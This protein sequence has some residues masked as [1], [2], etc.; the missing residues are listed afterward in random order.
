[1]LIRSLFTTTPLSRFLVHELRRLP[2]MPF[3]SFLTPMM[4]FAMLVAVRGKCSLMQFVRLMQNLRMILLALAGMNTTMRLNP[5]IM[6]MPPCHLVRV[7]TMIGRLSHRLVRPTLRHHRSLTTTT[8]LEIHLPR[9]MKSSLVLSHHITS[10]RRRRRVRVR[11][12]QTIP[13]SH[14]P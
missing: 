14:R 9:M 1:M 6:L 2:R 13:I 12:R 3:A 5:R 8:T 10:L 4:R 11:M 7:P